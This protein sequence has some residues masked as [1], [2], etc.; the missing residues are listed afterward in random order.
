MFG[1]IRRGVLWLGWIGHDLCTSDRGAK[2]RY[3]ALLPTVY[4]PVSEEQKNT[5]FPYSLLD[6]FG[7]LSPFCSEGNQPVTVL[8][9]GSEP[10]EPSG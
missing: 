8:L 1:S 5:S 3:F 10:D 6:T 7:A 9:S 2:S 4:T